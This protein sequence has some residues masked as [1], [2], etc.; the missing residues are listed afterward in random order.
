MDIGTQNAEHIVNIGS[1]SN[2]YSL[3]STASTLMG[4]DTKEAELAFLKSGECQAKHCAKTARQLGIISNELAKHTPMDAVWDM[5]HPDWLAPWNGNLASTVSSCAN[6][7]TT[8][9]GNPMLP[10]LIGLLRYAAD[11]DEDIVVI[12]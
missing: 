10:E 4:R 1:A 3:Y 9:D 6:L 5:D 7:Y 8:S 2:L 11:N 12:G